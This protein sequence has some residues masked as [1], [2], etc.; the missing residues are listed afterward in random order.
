[1]FWIWVYFLGGGYGLVVGMVMD[2]RETGGE[3]RFTL[4][5]SVSD[6]GVVLRSKVR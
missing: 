4:T 2:E 1:M 5:T 6:A 3:D